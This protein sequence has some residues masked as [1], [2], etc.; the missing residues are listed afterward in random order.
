MVKRPEYWRSKFTSASSNVV[1][2]IKLGVVVCVYGTPAQ[3]W[4]FRSMHGLP[5]VVDRSRVGEAIGEVVLEV[6]SV[7]IRSV[8]CLFQ[9]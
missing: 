5:R 6:V 2:P 7:V 4:T 9:I 1:C 8:T 3:S